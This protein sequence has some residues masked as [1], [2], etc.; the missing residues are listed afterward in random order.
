M[1]IE[2]SEN[3]AYM[4]K[5][6]TAVLLA[7]LLVIFL[8]ILSYHPALNFSNLKERLEVLTAFATIGTLLVQRKELSLQ[9]KEL[10]E[11]RKILDKQALA[12]QE[13]VKLSALVAMLPIYEKMLTIKTNL[14]NSTDKNSREQVDLSDD[15]DQLT[16]KKQI[17]IHEIESILEKSNVDISM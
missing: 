13:N 12:H 11:N 17:V 16:L 6:N 9:R 3:M 8:I 15:I 2:I 7:I 5:K 4:F 10:S 1:K 14:L